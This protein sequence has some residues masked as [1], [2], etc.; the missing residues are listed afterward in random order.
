MI[1]RRLT[2]DDVN[3]AF[4]ALSTGEVIRQVITFD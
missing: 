2:L 3:D 1:T 4:A